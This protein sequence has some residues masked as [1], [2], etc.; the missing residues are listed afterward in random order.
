MTRN[1]HMT[2]KEKM[3]WLID[4]AEGFR[5]L[6]ARA[7]KFVR[8]LLDDAD[9]QVRAEAVSCLWNSS[10]PVWIQVLIDKA[11]Q[12]P[13]LDVR[14][15]GLS[16]LGHYIY[17]KEMSDY[18]DLDEDHEPIGDS[19]LQRIVSFLFAT[20]Q[21]SDLSVDE[22]R[23]AVESLAFLDDPAV[24]ALIEWAYEQQEPRYRVSAIFA[25]GRTGDLRWSEHILSELHSAN[26]EVQYE[27]VRA[28]GQ[29]GLQEATEDLIRLAHGRGV[30][31]SLRLIAIYALGE[32]GDDRAYPILEKLC[33]ARDRDVRDAAREATEE[34]L[35][36]SMADRYEM[37]EEDDVWP[38]S[39]DAMDYDEDFGVDIWDN[40]LGTFS[41][42]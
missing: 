22:R 26:R 14:T 42:N 37:N 3:N 18:Q 12:D 11:A 39:A 40:V 20:A 32:T 4:I 35:I 5:S 1:S 31:K 16:A 36:A 25:M 17:E 6:D 30:E 29:I 23:Y 10:D 9:P 13:N 34:W 8:Y 19:D 27:A 15:R 28:A 38:D 41:L 7:S 24:D 2:K 33:H 21:N